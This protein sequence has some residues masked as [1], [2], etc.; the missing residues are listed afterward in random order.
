MAFLP[1]SPAARTPHLA[2]VPLPD[3]APPARRGTPGDAPF[4]EAPAAAAEPPRAHPLRTSRGRLRLAAHA[5]GV[6]LLLLLGVG[7]PLKYL[8]G[9]PAATRVLGPLHGALFVLYLVL[10]AEVLAGTDAAG[11]AWGVRRGAAAVLAGLVPFG[12]F[13]LLDA[14]LAPRRAAGGARAPNDA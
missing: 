3:D 2:G 14:A 13:F 1:L 4:P 8:A 12:A 11:A 9:V 10:L 6:S 5:E 7:V